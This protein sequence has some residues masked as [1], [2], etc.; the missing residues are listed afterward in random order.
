MDHC[1]LV[2]KAAIYKSIKF[3]S[4]TN[5]PIILKKFCK[6]IIYHNHVRAQAELR[7]DRKECPSMK[8]KYTVKYVFNDEKTTLQEK[9]L[10]ILENR[11]KEREPIWMLQ[12]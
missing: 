8:S 10:M 3:Y 1:S 2:K 7:Q 4:V 6:M 5:T 12:R 11:E 9:L